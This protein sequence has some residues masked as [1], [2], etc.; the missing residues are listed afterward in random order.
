M[1]TVY[2]YFWLLAVL[3]LNLLCNITIGSMISI[4]LSKYNIIALALSVVT[5]VSFM[6]LDTYMVSY[7]DMH[8]SYQLASDMSYFSYTFKMTLIAMYG[9]NRC[10][11]NNTSNYVI[12][13]YDIKDSRIFYTYLTKFN[14]VYKSTIILNNISGSIESQSLTAIMGPSGA[15]KTTLFEH[16]LSGLTVKQILLYASKLKNSQIVKHLDH[17]K[18]VNDLMSEFLISDIADNCVT[19][20]SGGERKRIV[21]AS[22]LTSQIKPNLLIIDEPTSGLDSNAAIN[23]MQCLKSLSNY[24]LITIIVSIH[25]PNIE[26]FNI[27][28]NIY[29]LAK[30]GHAIYEESPGHLKQTVIETNIDFNDNEVPIEVLLKIASEVIDNEI[31]QNL[32]EKHKS[33]QNVLKDRIVSENLLTID[34][35][36]QF[37]TKRWYSSGTYFWSSSIVETLPILVYLIPFCLVVNMYRSWTMFGIYYTT[38]ILSVLC[39]QSL[40]QMLSTLLRKDIKTMLTLVLIVFFLS[41][42]LMSAL[43]PINEMHY[44]LQ[45]LS[46]LSFLS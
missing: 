3:T 27:F 15:G 21:I 4:I 16:L 8:Y 43:I 26:L 33:K 37:T 19:N 34:H 42:L 38:I 32:S 9:W 17:N 29:V 20:C 2:K 25:Q 45:L 14:K 39:A 30:G 23:I 36:N 18:I 31:V 46:N 44:S 1:I 5:M 10:P 28:D 11:N 13:E 12:L 35:T 7:D 22:E 40:S 6:S 41:Y 24:H